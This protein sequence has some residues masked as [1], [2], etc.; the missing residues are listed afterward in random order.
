M[1]DPTSLP[2]HTRRP[3]RLLGAA[4]AVV[5][6]AS[7][8]GCG[9]D[10]TSAVLDLDVTVVARPDSTPAFG[11]QDF[12]GDR[13]QIGSLEV[14]VDADDPSAGTFDLYV[15]RHLADPERRVGSLLVNPGGPGVAGSDFALYA[16]QVFSATLVAHFDIIGWDPRGVGLSEPA[17]DCIDDYDR[18]Y[19]DVD[20]TPDDDTERAAAIALAEEFQQGC[21]ERSGAFLA[22]VG[23][24]DSAADIDRIRQALGEPTVSYFGFSYG[25]ELGAAW[26]TLFPDTVRA[27][28]LDGAVDP[29]ADSGEA[30][31][32]QSV[33]FEQSLDA[34]FAWCDTDD[35]CA[36]QATGAGGAAAAFDAL[37]TSVDADPVPTVEGRPLLDLGVFNNGVVTALY[38]DELW[39]DLAE[40]LAAAAEGDGRG[41]LALHDLYF[42]RR[43]DGTWDNT[44]E[45]FQVIS[46]MDDPQRETPEE[47]QALLDEIRAAA[48]RVVPGTVAWPS[49]AAFPAPDEGRTTITGAGAGPIVV[50]GTTGDSATPLAGTRR[51]ADALEQG[52]LVVVEADQ[53][54][55]YGVN[56]CVTEAVDAYLV[57]G[58]LPAD[59]LTCS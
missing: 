59:G 1:S 37:V 21:V 8:A 17:V 19:A 6:L 44:L 36:F 57:G 27:A 50:V 55:G 42:D 31:L 32:Q 47:S 9:T 51:M 11:W 41:L 26:A 33:G 40:A 22:H 3:A 56:D 43:D 5:A 12:G 54:T 4:A 46:C 10:D 28:V 18:F 34:F 14:P 48:P 29:T 39:P 25:S 45:A 20:I 35:D 7:M 30:T 16:E 2:R 38:S 23:T 24:N 49:C 15:A 52:L 53:H 13:V 58:V